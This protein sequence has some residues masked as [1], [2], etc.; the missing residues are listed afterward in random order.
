MLKRAVEQEK[1]ENL[2]NGTPHLELT[3]SGD[4]TWK[5]R[6]FTSKYGITTIIGYHTK[7]VIDIAIKST[8]CSTCR[9]WANQKGTAEYEDWFETHQEQC[10]T[11][12]FGSAGKMEPDSVVNMFQTS[13]EKYGVRYAVYVGDGDSKTYTAIKNAKPYGDELLVQKK[14]V[15]AMWKR[16]WERGHVTRKYII[17]ELEGT[18]SENSPIKR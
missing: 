5:K 6:G 15:S 18:E 9:A 17:N 13:E 11:N 4:G 10:E 7:Q 8:F 14:N 16:G 1:Q 2:V 3:V 12:H